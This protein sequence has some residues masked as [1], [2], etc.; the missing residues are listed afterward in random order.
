MMWSF[1]VN[2][3]LYES[4]KNQIKALSLRRQ[5]FIVGLR[6]AFLTKFFGTCVFNVFTY[7]L[8]DEFFIAYWKVFL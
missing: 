3:F 2:Y 8:V 7:S 4:S 1:L 5:K 6:L